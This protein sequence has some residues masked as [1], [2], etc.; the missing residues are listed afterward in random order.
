MK[1]IIIFNKVKVFMITFIL[2][3]ELRMYI[4]KNIYSLQLQHLTKNRDD[5]ECCLIFMQ[6]CIK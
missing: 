3:D 1:Y 4:K 2:D 5:H 6:M